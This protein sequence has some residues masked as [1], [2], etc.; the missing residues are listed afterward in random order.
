MVRA[1]WLYIGA[2]VE[3]GE[4]IDDFKVFLGGLRQGTGKKCIEVV[5]LTTAR[6]IP[7]FAT[8]IRIVG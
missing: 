5:E 8:G 3:D 4:R 6:L 7:G 2:Q 1:P